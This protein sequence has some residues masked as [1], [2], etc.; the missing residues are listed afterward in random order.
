VTVLEGVREGLVNGEFDLALPVGRDAEVARGDRRAGR[1]RSQRA[2][3]TAHR[4]SLVHR[5]SAAP[6]Q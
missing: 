5:S 6:A 2:D 1:S 4:P 3:A